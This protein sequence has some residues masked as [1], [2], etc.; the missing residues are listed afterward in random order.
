MSCR[1][2]P[3]RP[4]PTDSG[5][6][7]SATRPFRASRGVRRDGDDRPV[8][9]LERGPSAVRGDATVEEVRFADEVGH[10]AIDRAEVDL[11]RRPDLADMPAGHDRDPRRH[12]EGF[13]LVVGD[14]HE[15]RPDLAV[16]A[17]QLDLHLLA[18]LEVERPERLVEQQHGRSL[19]ERAGQR[20][21]LGLAARQLPRVAVAVLGQADQLEVLADAPADLV[22]RQA[23]HPQP[24]RDVVGDGHVREERVV[25]EH[26]V[27]VAL[28]RRQVVDP[29]TLDAQLAGRER[30]EPA[31]QVERGGLPATGRPK[32]AEELA[33]LDL[34]R[35][36]VERHGLAVALGDVDE[37]DRGR[38]AGPAS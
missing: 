12:R 3:C 24:E 1:P 23:L 29:P 2:A 16:D 11:A 17:R 25:L 35:D 32:Q 14:E 33:R 27:H 37:L 30:D 21:A 36:P 20:H 26:G 7:I 28:V 31:D 8:A 6:I 5:R 38:R 34:E 18:E 19:R 4:T 13:L 10:E 22:V 15:G 9:Q